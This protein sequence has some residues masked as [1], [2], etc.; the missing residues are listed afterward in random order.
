MAGGVRP[1]GATSPHADGDAGSTEPLLLEVYFASDG[2]SPRGV[3]RELN[4]GPYPLREG[5]PLR[6]WESAPVGLAADPWNVYASFRS[7]G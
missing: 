1:G 3:A 4:D 2:L 5:L 7:P 6:L